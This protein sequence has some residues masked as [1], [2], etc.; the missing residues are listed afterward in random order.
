MV[1]S[2]DQDMVLR[3]LVF[4]LKRQWIIITKHLCLFS[5]C[6]KRCC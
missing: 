5:A 4:S 1:E 3:L 6:S 2:Q